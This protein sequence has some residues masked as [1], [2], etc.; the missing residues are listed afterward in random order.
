MSLR[1]NPESAGRQP[2]FSELSIETLRAVSRTAMGSAA[3]LLLD[4]G[5]LEGLTLKPEVE[6]WAEVQ[7]EYALK[8]W[9]R[10]TDI[11]DNPLSSQ[12]NGRDLQAVVDGLDKKLEALYEQ[13]Q[14]PELAHRDMELLLVPYGD[15]HK[16]MTE[17]SIKEWLALARRKAGFN[18]DT[19]PT[20]VIHHID[21]LLPLQYDDPQSHGFALSVYTQQMIQSHGDWGLLLIDKATT[22]YGKPLGELRQETLSRDFGITEWLALTMQ[23]DT[24]TTT[25]GESLLLPGSTF[26]ASG[27]Q[28]VLSGFYDDDGNSFGLEL[29][30][31]NSTYSDRGIRIMHNSAWK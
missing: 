3:D 23:E 30:P 2:Q 26:E 4:S 28:F 20:S 16:H 27:H 24:E 14:T 7:L 21:S 29:L 5:R 15:L 8:N 11:L 1:F 13:S 31:A 9:E 17:K 18:A 19:I 10:Y 25:R 22:Q 12:M 6:A